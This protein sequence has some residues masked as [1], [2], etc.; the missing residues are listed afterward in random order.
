MVLAFYL[1]QISRHI[2]RIKLIFV[3]LKKNLR[4]RFLLKV[5]ILCLKNEL[6]RSV[7]RGSLQSLKKEKASKFIVVKKRK[8]RTI[9]IATK[10]F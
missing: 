9:S 5:I 1:Y 10:K 3:S 4:K 7:E 2:K 6:K 8:G